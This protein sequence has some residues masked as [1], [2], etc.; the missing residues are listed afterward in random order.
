MKIPSMF[1]QDKF[2]FG[3]LA[4]LIIPIVFSSIF[5]GILLLLQSGFNILPNYPIVKPILLAMVPN[6]LL[7]RY[8]FVKLKYEHSGKG[9][10]IISVLLTIG[11]LIANHFIL[12]N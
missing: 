3:F 7:L 5:I 1:L 9:V 8:Y 4:G 6:L 11:I 2:S 10:L 12:T